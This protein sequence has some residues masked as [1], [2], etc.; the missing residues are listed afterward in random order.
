MALRLAEGL[1]AHG[2]ELLLLHHPAAAIREPWRALGHRSAGVLRGRDALLLPNALS[3]LALRRFRPDVLMA[4]MAWPHDLALFMPAVQRLGVPVVVRCALAGTLRPG[5]RDEAYLRAAARFITVSE[6]LKRE[7]L[8]ALPGLDAPVTPILNGTDIEAFEQVAPA[9][10]D[11]PAGA[12]A[13]GFIGRMHE[14]KGLYE[15]AAAWPRVAAAVPDAWLVI[16]GSGGPHQEHVRAAFGGLPRVRMLG[17]RTDNIA[18]HLAFD[19]LVLPSHREGFPNVVVEAMAAGT[20]VV[21]T[22][23]SGTVEAVEPNVTGLLVPPRDPDAL[24]GA[25][26][27]LAADQPLRRR[28]GTVAA[29]RARERFAWPRAFNAYEAELLAAAH[30]DGIAQD[31]TIR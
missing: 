22:S 25:L 7:L 30:S 1:G 20:P 28:M 29:A 8:A 27:R 13:L 9:D 19:V 4:F 18:L 12:V 5:P 31:R 21:A 10:L 16:A 26:I 14:E 3:W 24:A 23:I 17:Y 11:L 6:D 15:L 2:H